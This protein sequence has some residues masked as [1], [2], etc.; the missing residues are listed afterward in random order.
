MV[1]RDSSIHNLLI[2]GFSFVILGGFS[3][4]SDIEPVWVGS[5]RYYFFIIGITLII[6]AIVLRQNKKTAQ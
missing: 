3:L 2:L 4:G 1:E 5:L 6:A